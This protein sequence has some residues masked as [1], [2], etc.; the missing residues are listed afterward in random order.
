[1]DAS[2]LAPAGTLYL[3]GTPIGNLGDMTFRAVET[4]KAVDVI[5]AEDTRETRKILQRFE[6][7]RPLASY[8]EHNRQEAGPRLIAR[9]K[10]GE[11]I[12]LVTDAGMPGISD[13]G[14]DLVRLAIEDGIPVVPIP[15]PTAVTTALVVS[16]LP[17]GRFAFEG[18]LPREPKL[19]RRRLRE[20]AAEPRTLVFYEAPHRL[21]DTLKDM[22]EAWGADRAATVAREL[23]KRF[24]ELRRGDLGTLAAHYAAEAA[25]GEVVIVVAGAPEVESGPQEGWREAL[26]A[27]IASGKRPSDAAKEIARAYGVPRQEVYAASLEA[28]RPPGEKRT[29]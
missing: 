17:T 1:M 12:A 25:R 10:A 9:M 15:G 14:E 6:I 20:L 27:A 22:A 21:D 26:A 23:T 3:V 5:A 16:G 4:L 2:K 8:H 19:R 13:P 24:E 28:A 18:F 29:N 11:S 7:D